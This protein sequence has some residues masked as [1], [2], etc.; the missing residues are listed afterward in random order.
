M[1]RHSKNSIL[2]SYIQ[3]AKA[4]INSS[5][6]EHDTQFLKSKWGKYL[7]DAV[8]FFEEERN[9]SQAKAN[10]IFTIRNEKLN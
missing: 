10:C 2:Y 3:L 9:A 4:I 7:I 6:R 5:I 1:A 8:S